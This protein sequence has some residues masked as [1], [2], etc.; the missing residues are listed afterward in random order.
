[1]W[2][3]YLGGSIERSVVAVPVVPMYVEALLERE[4]V[5]CLEGE[6]I[7]LL[8]EKEEDIPSIS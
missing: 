1:L 8:P 3:T 2:R 6:E 5:L 4:A 7:E